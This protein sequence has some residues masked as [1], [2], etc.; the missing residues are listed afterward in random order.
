MPKPDLIV[1]VSNGS[2]EVY[3][4]TGTSAAPVFTRQVAWDVPDI[5]SDAAPGYGDFDGDQD[6]DVLVG[7]SVGGLKGY[8]NTGTG[9][10][11]IW[12]PVPAW[13][14]TNTGTISKVPTFGDLDADGDL[15]MVVGNSNGVSYGYRNNGNV[16]SPSWSTRT[17]WDVY[18]VGSNASPVLVDLD[19]DGDLDVLVGNSVGAILAYRNTGTP[20]SLTWSRHAA[21][22]PSSIIGTNATP[23]VGDRDGDGDYDL[24]VG[25]AL[26]TAYAYTNIGTRTSPNWSSAPLHNVL[27]LGTNAQII[28]PDLDENGAAALTPWDFIMA[29]PTL[30]SGS[31][32]QEGAIYRFPGAKYGVDVL[33]QI[34][35]LVDA[36]LTEIDAT[37][38]GFFEAFQPFITIDGN[39]SGYAEFQFTFVQAG[40]STPV[41]QSQVRATSIDV[42]GRTDNDIYEFERYQMA[43]GYP[44]YNAAGNQLT[45]SSSGGWISGQNI[46]GIDYPNID[47]TQTDVMF[48]VVAS[49]IST[50]SMRIGAD[51]D[52]G[53]SQTRQRSV[54]FR[55]F[56]YPN[57]ALPV[58][59]ITF[60]A[61]PTEDAVHLKWT[62]ASEQDC[63]FYTVERSVDGITW[64]E[65]SIVSGTNSHLAS[66]YSVTD[67]SP[68]SGTS[69]Y[70]LTQTDFD[71]TLTVLGCRMVTRSASAVVTVYPN[72]TPDR[73]HISLYSDQPA[74]YEVTL[75][76]VMGNVV[77]TTVVE[78]HANSCR[79][80]DIDREFPVGN[81]LATWTDGVEAGST[82]VVVA[83][84]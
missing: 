18:D 21:W 5:G 66:S 8:Q 47:T 51:N 36:T 28:M 64:S 19:D 27:L 9:A 61:R 2:S 25:S 41:S 63:N 38:T 40:T 54:Y 29:N 56:D 70:R 52:D 84:D 1:G 12:T 7:S 30:E 57:S 35:D 39:S 75:L 44:D 62:S 42:D 71:G 45:I 77:Y 13:D 55:R 76:G 74:R 26:G 73:V 14:I 69:Y 78:L 53:S 65:L 15:D 81:Y 6:F 60:E 50:F 79:T 83:G 72:P 34:V 10:S 82:V 49:N 23:T 17:S 67:A 20:G 48:S 37:S 22:D 16:S 11:P 80:I 4:N 32:L 58:V 31:A 68:M 43:G 3:R 59:L 46:G 33:V 24:Y